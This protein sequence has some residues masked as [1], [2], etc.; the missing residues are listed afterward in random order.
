MIPRLHLLGSMNHKLAECPSATDDPAVLFCRVC[1]LVYFYRRK[2]TFRCKSLCSSEVMPITSHD[3]FALCFL[4]PF[5][6]DL[7]QFTLDLVSS[8]L[9]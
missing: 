3:S 9:L 8:L 1:M 7:P 4:Y 5:P 6:A 2:F